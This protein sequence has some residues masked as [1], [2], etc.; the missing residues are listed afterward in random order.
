MAK[1]A[2]WLDREHKKA[3]RTSRREAMREYRDKLYQAAMAKERIEDIDDLLWIYYGLSRRAIERA[4]Y[5]RIGEL[6]ELGYSP[7]AIV[8]Q[9]GAKRGDDR[10]DG[11][12]RT[13]VWVSWYTG[14]CGYS[15]I[16]GG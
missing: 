11:C 5:H 1:I 15:G 4:I 7:R 9:M 2:A 10:D 16:A 6:A 14:T 13:Q 8:E 3:M 12:M